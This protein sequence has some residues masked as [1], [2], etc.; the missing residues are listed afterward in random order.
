MKEFISY[1]VGCMFGRYSLD[2]PGLIL[3]DQGETAEDYRG[4]GARIRHFPPD[5]DNVIPILD[6]GWFEDDIAGRF[7]QFLQVTFGTENYEENLAFLEDAIG[8][9][10]RSYFLKSFY[11]RAREDVQEAADLLAVFQPKRQ[12]Q[13]PHL[14][15]SL[16]SGH[17]FDHLERLS[18][19]VLRE[20]PHS[21]RAIGAG[22]R[23]RRA[24][25]EARRLKR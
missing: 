9:D 23:Q 3:A 22:E 10:I 1:A 12:L 8:K 21:P 7:K 4:S 17:N 24:L 18:A 14:H 13:C 6:E 15:A 19:A 5:E 20:T 25:V 2:K 11:K 16:S